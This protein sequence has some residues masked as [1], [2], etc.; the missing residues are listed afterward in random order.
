M[1]GL[2]TAAASRS[3]STAA[4]T[5]TT[6]STHPTQGSTPAIWGDT[7]GAILGA[8]QGVILGVILGIILGVTLE[9]TLETTLESTLV[10]PGSTGIRT[11]LGAATQA[12]TGAMV[13]GTGMIT[14]TMTEGRFCAEAKGCDTTPNKCSYVQ[15][16]AQ[17]P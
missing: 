17:R 11:V 16:G 4:S 7:L 12:T 2:T 1:R 5:A 10:T 15:A 3:P 13:P 9:S 6:T 14:T 8:I